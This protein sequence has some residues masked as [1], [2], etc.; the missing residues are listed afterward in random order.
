MFNIKMQTFYIEHFLFKE[1]NNINRF[2]IFYLKLFHLKIA[3]NKLILNK[4]I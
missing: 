3:I 1:P 4:I 2:H